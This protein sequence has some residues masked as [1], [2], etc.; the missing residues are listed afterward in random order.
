[1][2]QEKC[3]IWVLVVK[4][5]GYVVHF[6]PYQGV[7]KGKQVASSTKWSLGENVALCLMACLTATFSFEI[8]MDNYFTSFRLLTHLWVNKIWATG[9]FNKNRLCIGDKQ[10]QKE[11]CDHLKC[12][13]QAKKQCNFVSGWLERQQGGLHSFFWIL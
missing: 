7:K 13:H 12:T 2:T 4:V 1:M 8:F 10:L 6:R 11:E 5:Y 3:K 9:V